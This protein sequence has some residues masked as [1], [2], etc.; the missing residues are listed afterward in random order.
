MIP[1]EEIFQMAIESARNHVAIA[2][3]K[4]RESGEPMT[5]NQTALAVQSCYYAI[6][7]TVDCLR[8]DKRIR[9]A[10]SD[11]S[12]TE[13]ETFVLNKHAIRTSKN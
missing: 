3:R 12:P 8:E 7:E 10:V 13:S 4:S 6:L 1:K 11:F 9:R 5:R 2:A